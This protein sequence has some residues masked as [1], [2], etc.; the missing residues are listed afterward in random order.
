MKL[1]TP[2]LLT[3][4]VSSVMTGTLSDTLLESFSQDSSSH[5]DLDQHNESL[6]HIK[7]T[8]AESTS[9]GHFFDQGDNSHSSQISLDAAGSNHIVDF[10]Y[11]QAF[12]R[13]DHDADVIVPIAGEWVFSVDQWGISTPEI[14][15]TGP[16]AWA[17]VNLGRTFSSGTY[18][19]LTLRAEE[20][21]IT[22]VDYYSSYT[23]TLSNYY[24]GSYLNQWTPSY[25]GRAGDVDH[26]FRLRYQN[27]APSVGSL[28]SITRTYG[29]PIQFSTT[30]ISD[31]DGDSFTCGWDLSYVVSQGFRQERTGCN[32]FT[33][34]H[35]QYISLLGAGQF[36]Y[37]LRVRD[38][39]NAETIRTGILTLNNNRP[40]VTGP[41]SLR[42]NN[43]TP[44]NINWNLND[45][46]LDN[47]RI[48]VN[49]V[50]YRTGT[51]SLTQLSI[52]ASFQFSQVG[53]YAITIIVEDTLGLT[54]TQTVNVEILDVDKLT[55]PTVISPN[56]GEE[57]TGTVK[58]EW[59][60]ATDIWGHPITYDVYYSSTSGADWVLISSGLSVT[61]LQWNTNT[62]PKT[63]GYLIKVIARDGS[64]SSEDISDG[65]FTIHPPHSMSIPSVLY[66][67]NGESVFGNV[68]V[69]WRL[70]TDNWG[71]TVYYD[72]YYSPDAGTTWTVIVKNLS[73]TTYSWD[74]SGLT[75]S[76]YL[77]K[78]E[79]HDTEANIVED[80]SDMKFTILPPH[81]LTAA[82]ISYPTTSDTI[83]GTVI[84]TWSG[85][86]D[87]WGHSLAYDLYYTSDGSNFVLISSNI[88]TTDFSWQTSGLPDGDS[89]QLKILTRDNV[90]NEVES[91][92]G[93][94]SID[95]IVETKT[96]TTTS[97]IEPTTTTT[98]TTT[99]TS[100]TTTDQTS[101]STT[102]SSSE[103][104]T[105]EEETSTTTSDD[106]E[107]PTSAEDPLPVLMIGEVILILGMIGWRIR[108]SRR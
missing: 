61:S 33:L 36:T 31:P 90:G 99:T 67:N 68:L 3:I 23:L 7:D 80:I 39:Y 59:T 108:K 69:E 74:T 24:S 107:K 12:I 50:T 21:D 44:F 19:Q 97:T 45:R 20:M 95:N 104:T 49:S 34:T 48:L 76:E 60:A 106:D 73:Q 15:V 5:S 75:G 4:L 87:N 58:V 53:N 93:R 51:L 11:T 42:N 103:S 26:Y 66:P 25:Y 38:Y 2:L 63:S 8:T 100:T 70:V 92:T 62:L 85:A 28:P 40:Q 71:H 86:S 43:A 14:S 84:V 56:G 13:D 91:V 57:L 17:T 47:Y 105:T 46:N 1:V 94:F 22:G 37:A 35:N 10:Q 78:V 52:G 41:S 30:S 101:S 81:A 9:G 83:S 16:N 102:E 96:T 79:A 89:Y 64:L 82:T 29:D 32:S 54:G 55:I 88:L 98:T 72:L 6:K 65:T 27:R 77:I 18:S